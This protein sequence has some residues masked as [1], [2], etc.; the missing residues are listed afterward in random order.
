MT[1]NACKE[2][3]QKDIVVVPIIDVPITKFVIALKKKRVS[4]LYRIEFIA[5]NTQDLNFFFLE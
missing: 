2:S 3:K 1:P 5:Y 4:C